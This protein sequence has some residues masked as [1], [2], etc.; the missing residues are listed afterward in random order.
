V[1]V[2][3]VTNLKAGTLA[4]QTSWSE[5]RQT[6]FV[7]NF[8]QWIGL[9]HELAQLIGSEEAV[10]YRAQGTG[11]DQI[12]WGKYLVVA[13]VHALADGT[14]HT[15]QTNA[16]LRIQ[17]LTNGTNTAV[18]EV[19]DIV[20]ICLRVRQLNEVLHNRNDVFFGQNAHVAAGS[21]A[22]LAV[23]AVTTYFAQIVTFIR[24]EQLLNDLTRRFFIWRLRIT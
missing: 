7:G 12:G 24:E 4:R 11:V 2:V 18:R 10:D 9:V 20:H 22:Q 14:G 19:V 23:D 21:H 3:Y 16:K 15:G 17:L 5:C 6:T 13:D 1:G 8:G